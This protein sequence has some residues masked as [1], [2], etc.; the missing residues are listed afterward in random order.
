MPWLAD[1]RTRDA[2]GC[3]AHRRA[4]AARIRW[5]NARAVAAG[6]A[7][8]SCAA[9]ELPPGTPKTSVARP[10]GR[11]MKS[12]LRSTLC[13]DAC[14]SRSEEHTSELQSLMRISYAVIC[15]KKQIKQIQ[16]LLRK[17]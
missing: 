16:T 6:I 7:G 1:D 17:T 11:R 5:R 3:V 2:E 10:S 12:L 4:F 9:S 14:G 8:I 15:S 13:T